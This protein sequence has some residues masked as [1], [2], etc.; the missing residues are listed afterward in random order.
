MA[1]FSEASASSELRSRLGLRA[2]DFVIGKIGRLAPL[3]GH[4]DLIAAAPAILR[5]CPDA[6]FLIVGA[7]KLRTEIEGRIQAAG[8]AEKFILTGLVS[9]AEVPA[10][11]ALM[12]CLVHLSYREALSRALPQALAAGKP[13]IAYD[14]DGADEV[15]LEG[16]TGFVLRQ[17]DVPG[18]SDRVLRLAG[19]AELRARMGA[20]GRMLVCAE[21]TVERM[22]QTQYDVYRRLAAA[23][24]I[25]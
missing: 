25:T 13:V 3:K 9:P 20:R 21:F 23:R 19:D 22:V 8:L 15:C 17:G 6:R 4:A 16:E 24:G 2:E 5:G 11:L 18:V 10:H 1:P 7:G 12:D 14:F